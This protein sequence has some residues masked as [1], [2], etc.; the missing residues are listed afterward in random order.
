MFSDVSFAYPFVLIFLLAVPAL[1]YWYWKKKEKVTPDVTFSSLQLFGKAPVTLKEKFAHVPSYLR[2]LALTFL[3]IAAARPQSFSSGE[4]FYTEGIDIAMVL[5]ISG[6]MLAEDFKPN[7]LEAAKKVIDEFIKGRTVDKIGLVIFSGESFTQCPLTIDYSVLRNLLKDIQM[8][9]I[10]DGT[11]IGNAIANG[12]NRLKDSKAKSKVMILL[13]DG[14]NNAGHIDPLTAA[15]IAQKFGIRI[16]AI[17]V[18]TMGQAPYPFQTPFGIR[19]QM[20]PVEIDENILKQIA[21]ATGGKYFRAT[22]NRKLAQIYDEIDHLEKTRVEVTS[23]RHARELYFGWALA[24]LLL[25]FVEVA[26]SKT[27]LKRL[28]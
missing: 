25:L 21:S 11:A 12:V 2:L 17:G 22:N 7:R 28:P 23:Y 9:M 5:D 10:E 24:G 4:N 18:G 8:G 26:L 3:I 15:Q 19:Y 27:Y 1:A 20:V 13:T 16:Y 14:V 6:S